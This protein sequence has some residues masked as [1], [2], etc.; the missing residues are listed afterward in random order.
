[1]KCIQFIVIMSISEDGKVEE[2][3]IDYKIMI[4]YAFEDGLSIY[5]TDIPLKEV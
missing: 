3:K 4:V 2:S 1:M 5:Q